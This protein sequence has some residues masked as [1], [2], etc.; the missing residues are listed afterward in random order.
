MEHNGSSPDQI[1]LQ[2]AYENYKPLLVHA[3]SRL[4]EQGLPVRSQRI[5]DII[6]SFFLDTW[7]SIQA[8]FD[9]EEGDLAPYV[10]TAFSRYA[11]RHLG[12]EH[13][14]SHQLLD[15]DALE[16]YA[17]A[18]D[19]SRA[20]DAQIDA[21]TTRA[22]L[23]Q[24]PD[25]EA[26]LLNDYLHYPSERRLAR[27]RSLSRYR[28]HQILTKAVA[29][30]ATHLNA[31]PSGI[32]KDDWKVTRRILAG[33]RTVQQAARFL[34]RPETE[35][36][37]THRQ[38]LETLLTTLRATL[39]NQSPSSDMAPP[40]TPSRQRTKTP[41]S[42]L[43]ISDLVQRALSR[44]P[45]DD[46]LDAVEE[47]ASEVLTYLEETVQD[48]PTAP[49][50]EP[51]FLRRLAQGLSTGFDLE[52]VATDD[53][54]T[55][56]DRGER[57]IGEAFYHLLSDTLPEALRDFEQVFASVE[58]PNLPAQY[59]RQYRNGASFQAAPKTMGVLARYNLSPLK[60][61]YA[62]DSVYDLIDRMQWEGALPEDA[63]PQIRRQEGE[64][65]AS[66]EPFSI[67]TLRAEI[68]AVCECEPAVAQA[69]LTW[70]VQVAERRPYLIPHLR[71]KGVPGGGI[72]LFPS[73]RAN[74]DLATQW[75]KVRQPASPA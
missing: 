50:P 36:R 40:L 61:F 73:D 35:V 47:R 42:E 49:Q 1:D 16:E 33:G 12:R 29:R 43:D 21:E 57:D 66:P 13:Q 7:P 46:I 37:D 63:V 19:P 53:F 32:S 70:M 74:A 45:S 72:Q 54:L 8:N 14:R 27:E 34:D 64:L 9:P 55:A 44:D 28:V 17:D 52:S 75:E 31:P 69:L 15:T 24:L 4:S 26:S 62:L 6:H 41:P 59:V 71:A 38:N 18:R 2:S 65:R 56:T 30:L 48:D 23:R 5:L 58:P 3:L 60:V 20:L 51:A 67:S 39:T 11:R 22:V 68:Q 10:Y 25:E